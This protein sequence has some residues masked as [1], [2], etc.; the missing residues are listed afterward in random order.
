MGRLLLTVRIS[1]EVQKLKA[2]KRK[3]LKTKVWLPTK[4]LK[5]RLP[6]RLLKI[7]L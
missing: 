3:E 7:I 5:A 2:P 4:T 1:K 6:L